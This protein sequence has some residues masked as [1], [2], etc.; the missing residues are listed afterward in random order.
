[1]SNLLDAAH[2]YAARGLPVFPLWPVL[3][4]KYGV[5]C[6]CGRG[7]RCESP[8]KHP[9]GTLVPNGLKSA[10]T[11]NKMITDWWAAWPNANIGIA[12]GDVVVI[13]IDPRHGGDA[14][15]ARLEEKHGK[16]PPT[17]RVRTGGGGLHIYLSAPPNV[18]IKNSTGQLGDGLDVRGHGG[19]VV[20]P[21]S[22][23]VSG[24]E[25]EWTADHDL[26]GVPDWLVATLRQPG[27]KPVTAPADWR[28]LVRNGVIEGKRNDATA[29]LAGHLLR[30]SVDPRV[31]LELV[32]A[33]NIARC[34]PPLPPSEVVIIVNSIAR[35]ELERRQAS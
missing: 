1:M 21:P 30:R 3:P 27:L 22:K 24:K 31:T 17:R 34:Q 25:Y 33:W 7:T 29:R 8:G 26:A 18:T 28:E 2:R 9:L 11:D 32:L 6:G 13:D 23:H 14:A 35:L 15:L 12:T 19:Y 4:F 20:A 16:F 5:T 10:T